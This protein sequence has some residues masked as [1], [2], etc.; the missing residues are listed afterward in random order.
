MKNKTKLVLTFILITFI[1][2]ICY[3]NINSK[4]YSNKAEEVYYAKP[5]L[6]LYPKKETD[7][8]VTFEKPELLKT[9]YPKYGKDGWKVTAKKNG[10]LTDKKKNYYYALYWEEKGSTKVDFSKGYYVTKDEALTFLEDKLKYI[11]LTDRERNEFIMYWLPILEKNKKSLVYFELTEERDKYNKINI[12]PKPDSILRVA[13]HVKKVNKK[14][15]IDK[16]KLSN[17]NRKGYTAV[18][19]GGVIHKS[20]KKNK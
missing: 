14:T 17:F 18:E 3:L 13:I 20:S 7:I 11:G 15:K 8:K 10:D 9:T 12:E 2:G 5:V 6:Y 16:Q 4:S 1:S 19:W